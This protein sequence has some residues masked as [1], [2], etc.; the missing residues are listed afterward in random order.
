E[1]P[2][3]TRASLRCRPAGST[4]CVPCLSPRGAAGCGSP[5][6]GTAGIRRLAT[7]PRNG[8]TN[9]PTMDFP[10]F[11]SFTLTN[12]CNLRCTMCGQWS[13][14]GYIRSGQGYRG[15]PLDLEEW[16]RLADEI[17]RHGVSS[18]LL[19]GGEPLM[20]PGIVP[21]LEHL[22]GLGLFVSIDSNG[23]RLGDF[24]AD[25][26]RLGGIHV[27]VSVDGTEAVH[28][29]VRGLPGCFAQIRNSLA[30]LAE[31][32]R[33]TPPRISRSICFTISPWS[34]RALG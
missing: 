28:D 16:K 3:P 9:G 30:R 32:D 22:R 14:E 13:P 29:A 26:V 23:T 4:V 33:G 21:L 25:L 24:A 5:F 19:R 15:R 11:V 2:V 31:L 18:V 1:L 17:V 6:P 10:S 34:V 7:A 8:Q 20:F 27:T 12:A